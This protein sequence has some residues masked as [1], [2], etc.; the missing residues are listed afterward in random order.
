MDSDAMEKM[1]SNE[2]EPV[3][4][5]LI[6]ES[7]CAPEPELIARWKSGREARLSEARGSKA[8]LLEIVS[9][10]G[11]LELTVRF[12]SEGAKI[13]LPSGRLN[14]V[15]DQLSFQSESMKFEVGKDVEWEVGGQF[16]VNSRETIL[17]SED[18][19]AIN[20]RFLKLNCDDKTTETGKTSQDKMNLN[21][22]KNWT[23]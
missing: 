22:E 2:S 4:A 9:P 21:E 20:G 23:S 19:I 16:M 18:D 17:K 8:D 7:N 12:T 10:A 14:V 6:E 5:R 1:K 15:A 13:V 3:V 11:D